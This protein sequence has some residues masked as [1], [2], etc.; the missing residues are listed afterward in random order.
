MSIQK[1]YNHTIYASY[2]GYI[3]QAIV[4]N[5]APLLFLTFSRQFSLTLDRIALI[6]TMNFAIQLLVDL[7]SAKLID[8]IGYRVSVV[9][10]HV[11]SAAGLLGLAILPEVMRDAYAGILISVVLYAIGGGLIEVM[12]S[13][14]VESCPTEKKEAAMS[15]LHSFYCWGHVGVILVSTLYFRLA[16]IEH[17]PVLAGLW[18]IIPALNCF[19]FAKVPIYPVSG[20]KEPLSLGRLFGQKVF[21]LLMVIMV[22]AGASEQAMSQWASAFA[23]SALHVSKT[24]GD[25]MGP[26][27]F[28]LLMGT[29]RALYGKHSD[30]LPLKK[31]MTLC[32]FL[33]ILAYLLAAL[34]QNPILGLLGC[35]ICGFSVGIFWPGTF[36]M[37]ARSLPQAGTAMY[38]FMALAGDV[39]CS[40]GPTLVGFAANA[41]DGDLKKGIL[42]ALIFP[43][44]IIL[45]V[46]FFKGDPAKESSRPS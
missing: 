7:L 19:Y 8:R 35:G 31:A 9:A 3:T 4:N 38:A 18:A 5:F 6:T 44:M 27:A 12:I 25:L 40:G 39:G 14:I 10:A 15:L 22:C 33:C 29:A 28:A 30:A 21:W 26:C 45:G 41:M 11:F 13:P 23:E 42:T 1:D 17:W 37:A 46:G 32:G 20:E 36:S 43:I 34:T 16:G 24:V 2:I